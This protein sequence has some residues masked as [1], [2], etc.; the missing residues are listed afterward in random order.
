MK[1]IVT[2]IVFTIELQVDSSH[3]LLLKILLEELNIKKDLWHQI[4]S[5]FSKYCENVLKIGGRHFEKLS[6]LKNAVWIQ[7]SLN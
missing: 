6:R 2:I 5:S 1:L 3:E 7:Y 4:V